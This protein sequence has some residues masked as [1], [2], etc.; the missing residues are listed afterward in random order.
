MTVLGGTAN[1]TTIALGSVGQVVEQ[2]G[3]AG[4]RRAPWAG[5]VCVVTAACAL[6]PVACGSTPSARTSAQ[7]STS[8]QRSTSAAIIPSVHTPTHPLSSSAITAPTAVPAR[9]RRSRIDRIVDVAK[10]SYHSETK[11]RALSQ[12]L[13]RI[14]R[15]GVLLNDLSR[16]DAAG[17]QAEAD[18]QLRSPGNHFAHVTRISVVRGS[19]V[20]V[21]ATVNSDGVFVVAPGSR[22]LRSHGRLLGTL[23]VSIQDVTGYVKVVHDLT[24]ADVVARGAS[25]RVRTSRGAPTGGHLP[26]S[27]NVTIAGRRYFVRSFRE[28]G[29]GG[30][31]LMVWILERA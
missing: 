12:Q 14:A 10:S 11:G 13:G 2:A 6:A 18:A 19:R 21:N 4:R 9:H 3:R 27:G 7:R 24:G 26:R 29:W 1:E 30:E 16:G 17:A 5:S 20:L 31:P 25:G 22:A 23:L 8:T 15:D 28:V